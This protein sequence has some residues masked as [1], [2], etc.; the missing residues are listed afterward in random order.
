VK[1]RG[2]CVKGRK[3]EPCSVKKFEKNTITAKVMEKKQKCLSYD[4]DFSMG[5]GGGGGGVGV[6]WGLGGGGVGGG[7]EVRGGLGEG[8]IRKKN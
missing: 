2:S 3:E 5:W 8:T 1:A 4:T 6:G 7:G